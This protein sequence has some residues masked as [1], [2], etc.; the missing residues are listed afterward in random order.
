MHL[1]KQVKSRLKKKQNTRE[2]IRNSIT[3][4][5]DTIE[6]QFEKLKRERNSYGILGDLQSARNA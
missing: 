6:I 4:D 3:K 2:I 5:K 1:N